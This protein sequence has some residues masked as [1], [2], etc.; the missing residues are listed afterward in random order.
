MSTENTEPL[1]RATSATTEHRQIPLDQIKIDKDLFCHRNPEAL[2]PEKL[3]TM[4]DSLILE[5]IQVPVEVFKN[6]KGNYTLIKGHRR[7]SACRLLADKNEPGF[8]RDMLIPALELM[9]SSPADRLI[10]SISDN[11]VRLNLDR[12]SRIRVAKKLYDAGISVDRAARAMGMSTKN[13]GRDLLIAQNGWMFQH[14][15]DDSID[16]THAYDLLVGAQKAE[17]VT[18]MRE[19]LDAWIAQKKAIIREKEK[20]RKASGG[21]ELSA[22]DKRVKKFLPKHLV[23]HWQDLLKQKKRFDDDAHWNFAAS[24]ESETEQLRI[25][26]VS[27]DLAKAPLDRIAKVASKLSL[28]SK[29]M[30]PYLIKAIAKASGAETTPTAES[31]YD[32]E[33]LRKVGLKDYAEKLAAQTQTESQPDGE[34]SPQEE[35]STRQEQNL[36]QEIA[37]PPVTPTPASPPPEQSPTGQEEPKQ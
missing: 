28:L 11:E 18:E 5:N 32:L 9:S 17:R 2:L 24:I 1:S 16:P 33:Y 19:D 8:T 22:A 30:E 27:L 10:R 15:I 3:E 6:E 4:M 37:L 14:V 31:S 29:Q 36:T 23:T 7:V 20:I 12:V 25:S 21:K 26:S 13:Y 35:P 34:D